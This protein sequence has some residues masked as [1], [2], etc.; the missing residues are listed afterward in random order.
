MIKLFDD[1]LYELNLNTYKTL[2]CINKFDYYWLVI[3]M[4]MCVKVFSTKKKKQTNLLYKR[5]FCVFPKAIL[6]DC[7]F[8]KS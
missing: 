2:S 7:Y 6:F 4:L 1:V 5:V 8:H 3:I